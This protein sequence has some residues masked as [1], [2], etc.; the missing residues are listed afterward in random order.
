RRSTQPATR[1]AIAS[2]PER[3]R[4]RAI[5][6]A[7]P[8]MPLRPRRRLGGADDQ[9]ARAPPVRPSET[10]GRDAGSGRHARELRQDVPPVRPERLFLAL[11]HQVDVELVDADRLELA[12]LLRGLLGGAEDAEAIADLVRDELPVLRAHAAVVL[13]VVELACADEVGERGRDLGVEPV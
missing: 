3:R 4:I 5:V 13:V 8:A 1:T 2:R 9:G 11:R 7:P 10:T 6:A 12:Q